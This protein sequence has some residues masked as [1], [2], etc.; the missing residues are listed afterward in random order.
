[1]PLVLS[2]QHQ[3]R[4]AFLDL[5]AHLIE[6]LATVP[7]SGAQMLYCIFM[8]SITISVAPRLTSWPSWHGTPTTMPLIGAVELAA[9]D[10]VL[11]LVA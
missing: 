11:G 4:L 9:S 2:V 5:I 7:S 3:Q 8:A 6:H 10:L 1:M